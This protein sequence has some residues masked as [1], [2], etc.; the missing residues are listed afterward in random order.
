MVDSG[1][2]AALTANGLS[3]LTPP[4]YGEHQF[5][6]LY[7]DI[8]PNG[9]IT[10]AGA[11]SGFN[12]PL[13][14]RSRSA[15]SEN[16]ALMSVTPPNTVTANTLQ[17]RLN[18]LDVAGAR[19]IRIARDRSQPSMSGEWADRQRLTATTLADDTI[20]SLHG[21]LPPQGSYFVNRDSTSGSQT[22]RE[23]LSCQISEEDDEAP[24]GRETPTH[25]EYSAENLAKVPSYTTALRTNPRTPINEGLPSY[26]TATRNT[27][28]SPPS[29]P[30]LQQ[31]SMRG[32]A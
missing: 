6:Q 14:T 17:N 27:R 10:P 30:S 18:N 32:T 8:D 21:S 5:D 4:Q 12:T 1:G 31:R 15:S 25:V 24:S 29:E 11:Q 28:P 20:R 22:P 9:Y 13:Q 16:L 7:S 26:Q 23:D 3:D 2:R 19:E